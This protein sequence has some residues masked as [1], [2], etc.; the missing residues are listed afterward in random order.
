[1]GHRQLRRGS[2]VLHA[3]SRRLTIHSTSPCAP[4]HSGG[5]GLIG[6]KPVDCTQ[7]DVEE[8]APAANRL[9]QSF[10]NPFNPTTKIAF[11]VKAPAQ[12][13]LKIFDVSG[14]LVRVLVDETLTA[15]RHEIIW[16]GTDESGTK[17][18]SGIYFCRMTAG[19][20]A[21]SNKMILLR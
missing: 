13:S 15:G 18:A 11:E 10:P 20:F 21:E 2:A 3:G 7:T 4:A 12:V 5:C 17:V 16:N 1:M 6:A 14:R 9:H 8:T 19:T